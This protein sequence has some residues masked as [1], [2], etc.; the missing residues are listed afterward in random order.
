M[1]GLVRLGICSLVVAGLWRMVAGCS[2]DPGMTGSNPDLASVPDLM[3][4]M[5]SAP[6]KVTGFKQPAGAYFDAAT[7][8]WYV[9]NVDGDPTQVASLKDNKAAITKIP[10]SGGALGTPDHAFVNTGLSAP[11][12]MRVYN[13]N[14]YVGDVDQ[15]VVI[16]LSDKTTVA[17]S[18]AVAGQPLASL[19]GFLMDVFVDPADGIVYAVNATRGSVFRFT[20]AMTANN[21]G[22]EITGMLAFAGPTS[23]YLDGTKLVITEAGI[24]MVLNQMGGISTMNRDATAR[25]RLLTSNRNSLAYQGLEKDGGNY[26]LQPWHSTSGMS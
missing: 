18:T 7:S 2:D 21:T 8:A 3:Q 10:V 15:L 23:I 24:N 17:R 20:N 13:G 14:L 9:S 4:P 12:G 1:K 16:K 19:P 25:M 11:F 26:P 6:V 22:T 5:V